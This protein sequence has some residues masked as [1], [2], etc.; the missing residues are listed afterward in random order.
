MVRVDGATISD[1]AMVTLGL[2][3]A[4]VPPAYGSG[5]PGFNTVTFVDRA[6][7]LMLPEMLLKPWS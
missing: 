6:E 2:V 3:A 7:L 1:A 5:N 4:T